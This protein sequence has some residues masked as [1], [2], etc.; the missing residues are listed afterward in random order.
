VLFSADDPAHDRGL[1]F[2]PA[3]YIDLTLMQ[4]EPPYSG[5]RSRF[6]RVLLQRT[7]AQ[8]VR[9]G[10]LRL[11]AWLLTDELSKRCAHHATPRG[12]SRGISGLA[13]D[14][15]RRWRSGKTLAFFL[16]ARTDSLLPEPAFASADRSQN[17]KENFTRGLARGYCCWHDPARPH[18]TNPV[19]AERPS[20]SRLRLRLSSEHRSSLRLASRNCA[21]PAW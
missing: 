15:H 11:G 1:A 4:V 5:A 6:E 3:A 7:T 13:A 17:L 16:S 19:R 8:A 21:A 18:R 12:R 14:Y 10:E 2:A 9:D 20:G